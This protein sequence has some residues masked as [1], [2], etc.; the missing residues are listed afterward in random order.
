MPAQFRPRGADLVI[1]HGII[2]A[3][4]LNERCVFDFI[5]MP[6]GVDLGNSELF[7]SAIPELLK[8]AAS[9]DAGSA[10]IVSCLVRRMVTLVLR[11][12]WHERWWSRQWEAVMASSSRNSS[13][14]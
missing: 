14:P 9:D 8:E 1:A 12:A 6:H 7:A 3:T 13:R 5:V 2:A 11:D 4:L 10:A